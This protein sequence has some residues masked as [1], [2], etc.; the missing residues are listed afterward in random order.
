MKVFKPFK[1]KGVIDLK[2][3]VI[4]DHVTHGDLS[5]FKIRKSDLP[6]D[7]ET[8]EDIDF[9]VLAEGEAHAHAHQLFYNVVERP[10]FEVIEGAKSKAKFTL[11]RVKDGHMYLKVENEPLLLKHQTHNPFRIYPGF[12]DV[13]FQ[14][15]EDHVSET[16]RRIAD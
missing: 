7:F 12:Y 2:D 16:L 3:M 15:E 1:H 8:L 10:A 11:K 5:I 14:V 4:N 13:D 6:D 9:G